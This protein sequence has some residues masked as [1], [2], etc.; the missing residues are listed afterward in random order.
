[1]KSGSR[2]E[3]SIWNVSAVFVGHLTDVACSLAARMVFVRML[4]AEYL[5]MN[6]LFTNVQ[7]ILSLL[8]L[9]LGS[10]VLLSLYGP[11]A[12]EDRR[13]AASIIRFCRK[14]YR[15]M[16]AAMGLLGILIYPLISD[17]V[18][19]SAQVKSFG[20]Y[21]LIYLLSSVIYYWYGSRRMALLADQKSRVIFAR[22]YFWSCMRSVV[23]ILVLLWLR[24]YLLYLVM[25]LLFNWL[26]NI[27]I[28]R[29][30]GR[31]YPWLHGETEEIPSAV[32]SDIWKNTGAMFFHRIGT[33]FANATDSILAA[34]V[35]GI[36]AAGYYS[37][38]LL[39]LSL[40]QTL[41]DR[42]YEAVLGSV[43]NLDQEKDPDQEK[44][45]FDKINFLGFWIASCFSICL[46]YLLT[47]FISVFFGKEYELGRAT[48][49][50]V[51]LQFY[52]NAMR[53]P[54]LLFR[55]AKGLFRYDKYK[56]FAEAALKLGIS[57]YLG[58]RAGVAGI[59]AGSVCAVLLTCFWVEPLILFQ[60]GFHRKARTYF[61][62]YG[63][64]TVCFLLMAAAT[65]LP[66]M[67]L[68]GTGI[69]ILTLRCLCCL[70]IPNAVFWLIYG[71]NWKMQYW[72]RLFLCF[73]KD[74]GK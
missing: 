44:E 70:I 68:S 18:G 74:G 62:Q 72:M 73:C 39:A 63:K 57:L 56:P 12:R 55:D 3:N 11:M 66:I 25:L 64:D 42:V 21:Y 54:V 9:G 1:M 61:L 22:Q 43:G 2:T 24:S 15:R 31:L 30:A 32:R 50:L 5:G 52:L 69:G 40:L 71:R 37:N 38:Y 41:L 13:T 45:V 19:M 6:G 67:F 58:M 27:T 16:G 33:I 23:Q 28:D 14:M 10:A 4:S 34:G 7:G 51:G 59:A 8:E 60:K 65:G 53:R 46:L 35:Q 20:V 36:A 17:L 29:A 26:E 49:F 48:A 47:P